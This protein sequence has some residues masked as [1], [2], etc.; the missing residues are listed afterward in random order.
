[1]RAAVVPANGP[2]DIVEIRPDWPDPGPPGAGEVLIEVAAAALNPSDVKI[3]AGGRAPQAPHFPYVAGR[4]AAGRILHAGPGAEGFARDEAVFAFFGWNARP[5]GHAERLVVAASMVARR[6]VGTPVATAAAVPLAGLTAWQALRALDIPPGERV[7]VT[8]G[9][10]GVGHFAVQLAAHRGLEVV[11]TTGPANADFVRGLGANQVL[12]YHD[13]ATAGA[14]RGTRFLLDSVGPANI[15]SYQP[16]MAEGGRIAAVAGLPSE[17]RADLTATAIR[18]QPSGEDLSELAALLASGALTP[19]VQ[20]VFPLERVSDAHRL[21]EGGH[22]RGKL[23]I[24]L[25]GS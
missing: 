22:V 11:A 5:G 21:L 4:E 19:T 20:E 10:G 6:P 14:L 12:D 23:V 2:A 1:M 15:A 9:S 3:R 13:P 18:C 24:S 17:L 7:V 16:G 8:S 25:T